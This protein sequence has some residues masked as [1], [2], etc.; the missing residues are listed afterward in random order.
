MVYTVEISNDV[1]PL[2]AI[3]RLLEPLTETGMLAAPERICWGDV[4]ETDE[5]PECI[6]LHL[7]GTVEDSQKWEKRGF[8][9]TRNSE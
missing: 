4:E 1:V 2:W 7:N 6:I 8:K 3:R 5:K 9:V